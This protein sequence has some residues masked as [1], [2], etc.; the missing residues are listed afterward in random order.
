[1]DLFKITIGSTFE[2]ATPPQKQ[3]ADVTLLKFIKTGLTAIARQANDTK[4]MTIQQIQEN[5]N[6]EKNRSTTNLQAQVYFA[7]N[8]KNQP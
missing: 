6:G 2:E 5:D 7:R 3:V 4:K 1:M 8:N